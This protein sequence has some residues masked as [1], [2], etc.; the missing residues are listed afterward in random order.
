M[1]D[2]ITAALGYCCLHDSLRDRQNAA[3]ENLPVPHD[4]NKT[5]KKPCRIT[6]C[7][8]ISETQISGHS[9]GHKQK[10]MQ[11]SMWKGHYVTL[12]WHHLLIYK[13]LPPAVSK[14]AFHITSRTFLAHFFPLKCALAV[15]GP[16]YRFLF[17]QWSK[18]PQSTFKKQPTKTKKNKLQLVQ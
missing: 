11:I 1:C 13:L 5:Q 2:S 10:R 14:S 17:N 8:A 3:K 6:G 9:L 12:L 15:R 18:T 16:A 4:K 7:A